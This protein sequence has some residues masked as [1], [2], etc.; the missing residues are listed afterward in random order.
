MFGEFQRIEAMS[1]DTG[2][3]TDFLKIEIGWKTGSWL[4][5]EDSASIR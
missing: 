5:L 3:F 4:P 2:T 1:Y